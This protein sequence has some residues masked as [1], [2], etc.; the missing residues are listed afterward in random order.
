M[1]VRLCPG[2]LRWV[3]VTVLADTRAVRICLK[4][5]RTEACVAGWGLMTRKDRY[6]QVSELQ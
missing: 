2:T 4:E 3:T 6:D 5:M 1:S